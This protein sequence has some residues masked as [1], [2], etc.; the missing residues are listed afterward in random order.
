MNTY[1]SSDEKRI[2]YSERLL[3]K[4]ELLAASKAAVF[5]APSG[6]GKTTV[7]RGYVKDSVPPESDVYW[8][9]AVEEAPAAL[10]G[11]LCLE[12]GKIDSRVGERLVN[13]G[14]P[15]A[16][17]IGEVCDA[18]RSIECGRETWLVI[19]DYQHLFAFLPQPVLA[20]LLDHG[21]ERL[22]VVIITRMLGQ[23]FH[24]SIAARGIPYITVNDL[25]WEAEDIRE[26]FR[27]YGEDLTDAQA[28]E[29]KRITDGWVI[30]VH[31]QLCSRRE[32]GD[33]SD[34]AV[35][36]LMESL[37]WNKMN[38]ENREF[39]MRL[40]AFDS[41]SWE[42][43]RRFLN[44]D[45][46]PY[47]AAESL[48][49]PFIHYDAD[50]KV[51]RPHTILLELVRA[52]RGE[53]GE[54]FEKECL[55]NAGDMCRGEGETT[56]ALG[57][58]ARIKDYE[59]ILSLELAPL[60]CAEVGGGTFGDIAL[61]IARECPAETKAAYPLAMLC[62]AWAVRLAENEEEFKRLMEELDALLPET[63][64]LRAEWLL[65]SAYLDYPE[66]KKM[67]PP[68]R[69]AVLMFEG[70]RSQVI[71]PGAPW[72]FYEYLQLPAF[73]IEAGAADEEADTLEEFVDIY[74]RMTGGHGA[75]ADALFRAE[76]AFFRCE[77]SKAEIFA[78][79]AVFLAENRGQK[80][81]QIGAMRLLGAIALLK[82]DLE[83]WQSVLADVEQAAS[84]SAQNT[85]LFRTML[86]VVKGTLLAQLRDYDR[87][88]DWL[89]DADFM[90]LG[91]PASI[92]D[93]AAAVHGYYLMGR[94]EYARLVGFLQTIDNDRYTPFPEHFR[95]FSIAV[96]YASLGDREQAMKCLVLSAKKALPDGML[97]CFAGYS[98]L[99]GGLSDEFIEKEHPEF[100]ARLKDYKEQYFAGWATL[101][102][103]IVADELPGV[104]TEREL[105][106]AEMAAE[107]LH[108]YEIADALYVSEN[109]VRAHLR[110][111]YQKLDID[112]RA[113]LAQ[114]LK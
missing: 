90:S 18:L 82:S 87:I 14:V 22:H 43:M 69:K 101:H 102:D 91:L 19:D 52:K 99:L 5:E 67:L 107:G 65:L 46:A 54:A 93:K 105:E 61:E 104:L 12:I 51:Y 74:S 15:N 62:V 8:F 103:A 6:Y 70:G 48:S 40:S 106:I 80:I 44:W 58:Y 88:A 59:R 45:K 1:D 112:R 34:V 3:K 100:F 94:G 55:R 53:Q 113:K 81:I 10:Y 38:E 33:F 25:M 71:L 111:I 64:H 66:L 35:S 109:T 114:K 31:L 83:G 21:R 42:R 36:Q 78:Y 85:K 73:H 63:G 77:T 49:I 24:D 98:R 30:A 92:M 16:F 95:L 28:E 13:T 41:C 4:M 60:V 76:L 27:L 32:T 75:G 79:K 47:Y 20:T 2:Y 72:A 7:M 23:D 108:N 97:H 56:E 57:F 110:A 68:A 26:Y 84:G 50:K 86:D 9:A 89:K 17:T 39:F 29:V 96:G 37:I 11:R